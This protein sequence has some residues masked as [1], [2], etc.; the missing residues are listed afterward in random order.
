[1][2][3]KLC[4]NCGLVKPLSEFKNTPYQC[5]ECLNTYKRTRMAKRKEAGFKRTV[6]REYNKKSPREL[7]GASLR[8]ALKRRPTEDPIDI[9]GIMELWENQNGQCAVSKIKMVWGGDG[10]SKGKIRYNSVSIDR[11]D[12]NKGYQ[13]GNVRLVCYCLN[14]FMMDMTDDEA[15][16]VAMAFISHMKRD[17]PV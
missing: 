4:K 13:K 11:I 15:L 7:L 10:G 12:N 6:S 3:E 5:R 14:A 16:H 17:A 9:N 1:M 2:S 8:H